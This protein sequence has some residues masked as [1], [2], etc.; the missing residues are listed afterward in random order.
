MHV[1]SGQ[2]KLSAYLGSR[3]ATA[4]FAQDRADSLSVEGGTGHD[5]SLKDLSLLNHL[6][7]YAI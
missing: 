3:S 7:E 2:C 5:L 4:G 6:S 1:V